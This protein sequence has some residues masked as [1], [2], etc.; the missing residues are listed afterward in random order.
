MTDQPN[1]R[2]K[3]SGPQSLADA[4]AQ[5]RN[6]RRSRPPSSG[7]KIEPRESTVNYEAESHPASLAQRPVTCEVC[8]D[9][10]FITRNVPVGHPD[11]GQSFRCPACGGPPDLNRRE[12]R[13]LARLFEMYWMHDSPKLHQFDLDAF[14]YLEDYMDGYGAVGK[15]EAIKAAQHWA[16]GELLTYEM[17]PAPEPTATPFAPSHALL[18]YGSPGMGKTCLAAAAYAERLGDQL[19]LAIEYNM[20]MQ[21]LLAQIRDDGDV[22]RA[23]AKVARVPL[24]FIDDLGNTFLEGVETAGR[25]RWLF[26]I[27]NYRYNYRLPTIITTNLDYG[28]MCDQFSVKLAER[29]LEWAVW[30]RMHGPSLR[31]AYP[32]ERA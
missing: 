3:S 30:I 9:M 14:I 7:R 32:E 13:Q 12:Q 1:K 20:L 10:G 22:N 29:L 5:M 2:S 21:A 19:G 6:A 27:V 28:Q 11:F 17:I 24:L 25:L 16:A 31:I 26:E 15:G 23:V 18:L 8:G 4:L